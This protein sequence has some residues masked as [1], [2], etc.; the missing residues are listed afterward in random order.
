MPQAVWAAYLGIN[1]VGRERSKNRLG[2]QNMSSPMGALGLELGPRWGYRPSWWSCLLV[3]YPGGSL[4]LAIH[5]AADVHCGLLRVSHLPLL[6]SYTLL[7]PSVST[8]TICSQTCV[9]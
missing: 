2:A 6:G 4:R 5:L 8:T 7:V 3:L 9:L 1:E